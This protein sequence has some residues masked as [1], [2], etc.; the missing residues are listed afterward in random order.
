MDYL[1]RP[2]F[3]TYHNGI[4]TTTH[5]L[6]AC[7]RRLLRHTRSKYRLLRFHDLGGYLFEEIGVWFHA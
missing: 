4:C 3:P 6:E 1:P 2:R 7:G 5:G